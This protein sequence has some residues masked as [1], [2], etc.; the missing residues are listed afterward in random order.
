MEEEEVA[1]TSYGRRAGKPEGDKRGLVLVHT[2]EG[3]GKTTA[4][5]GLLMRA[6]GRGLR[7][8]LFQ[9]IKS[10]NAQFGEHHSLGKLGIPCDGLGDGFT[11]LSRDLERSR[12][13]AGEGWQLARGA[14]VSGEYDL[15][16]L[17]EIT[18]PMNWGWI[19]TEDVLA[20][21][22]ERPAHVHAVLTGRDA[23]QALIRLAD[24]VTEMRAVKHA[25]EAGVP[26]QRGIEH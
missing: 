24:T 14:L 12:A 17:D 13:I 18:Y 16:V 20:A 25:F 9:F 26:A 23:P 6:A 8:R 1:K 3:K 4:A 22:R 2:G 10:K 5:L 21:L 11:W 15:V 7:T 19:D